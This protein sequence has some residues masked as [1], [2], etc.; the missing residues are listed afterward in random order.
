MITPRALI[1][2]LDHTLA[3]TTAVW[4]RAQEQLAAYFGHTWND[5]LERLVR[6]L[7]AYDLAAAVHAHLRARR[8][9]HEAQRFMRA[10]LLA[11]YKSERIVEMPG[12]CA[13][14]RRLH[15]RVPLAVAS[16]SPHEG[17]TTALPQL[18]IA[19]LFDVVLASESVPRGKPHPDVFRAA[20]AAVGVAPGT[21]LVFEDSPAGVHAARAAGMLCFVVPHGPH[22]PAFSLATRCFAAWHEVQYEDVFGDR[23]S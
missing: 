15:G 19:A 9:V 5:A 22:D 1:F 17:I 11:A 2:D 4:Q 13:L 18:G 3:D 12:A 6:G 8:P 23:T 20:A 10:A 14:V 16:G 7:N 21:C